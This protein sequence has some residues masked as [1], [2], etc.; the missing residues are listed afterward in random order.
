[1]MHR[2]SMNDDR[3]RT[4]IALLVLSNLVLSLIVVF[5]LIHVVLRMYKFCVRTLSGE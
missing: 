1:M 5:S 2:L 4:K 3:R